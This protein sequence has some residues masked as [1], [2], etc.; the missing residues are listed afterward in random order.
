M[1]KA[2]VGGATPDKILLMV[3]IPCPAHGEKCKVCRG[4]GNIAATMTVGNLISI[5]VDETMTRLIAA[6]EEEEDA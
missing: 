2:A 5:I 1:A 6:A 3:S 4:T